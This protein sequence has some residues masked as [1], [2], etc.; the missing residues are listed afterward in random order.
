MCQVH[1]MAAHSSSCC[2]LYSQRKRSSFWEL[3]HE[4]KKIYFSKPPRKS[5][6]HMSLSIVWAHVHSWTLFCSR[7]MPCVDCHP[8]QELITEGGWDW[9]EQTWPTLGPASGV[10]CPYSRGWQLLLSG[11]RQQRLPI[12][13]FFH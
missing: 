1:F 9:V 8:N 10:N 5:S 2:F 7:E 11:K 4:N 3:F 13:L 6:S 12:L